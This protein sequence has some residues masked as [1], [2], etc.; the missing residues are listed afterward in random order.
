MIITTGLEPCMDTLYHATELAKRFGLDIVKRGDL[1]LKEM[2]S[3]HGD[4][5]VL[6]VSALGARLD[7]PGKKPFFF[8]PNTAAFR[9]KRLVRGDTDTM[10]VACQIQPGDRV[11]DATMGLG[12]DSIVFAHATG[13][14]GRVLGIESEEV[15]AILV[16]DGF[17]HWSSDDLA[18]EQAM[19]RIEVRCGNHLDVLKG[20]SDRSFDV[21]YFD[22][23]FEMTVQSS[24]G[25]AG[26]REYANPEA[27]HEEAVSEALRVAKKRVVLKEGK[28]GRMY[29]RFG[30][31]PFRS[32]GQQVVY[33]YKEIS[34]GE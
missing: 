26:I 8:H 21:V 4:E 30:F 9:I 27:L 12:A 31:T 34:G 1:S 3:R 17:Q 18:L 7:V 32:R 23:M 11:L 15:L 29:E 28:T 14:A 33:S 6:V 22:P 10:L 24:T 2:R 25:I 16:E 20:M 5:E 19:R 13:E